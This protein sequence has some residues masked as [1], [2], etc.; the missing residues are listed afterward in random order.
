MQI[1][2]E[3]VVLNKQFMESKNLRSNI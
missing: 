2:N 3:K 1:I